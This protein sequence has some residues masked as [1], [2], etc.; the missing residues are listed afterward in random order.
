M[1]NK[2]ILEVCLSPDL[3]GLELYMNKCI[4]QL[5]KDFNVVSTIAKNSKLE[6]YY[7]DSENKYFTLKRKSSFSLIN[8]IKLAKIIDSNNIDI[9]HL[10]W[11]KDL[12]IVVLAK[13]FSKRN[14]KLFSQDI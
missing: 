12:P 6:K 8:A 14:Q 11:T 13:V 4:K 2:N 9:V 10:H 1:T 3:G 7:K 5:S